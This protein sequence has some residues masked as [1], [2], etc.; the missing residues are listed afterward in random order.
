ML[1]LASLCVD[2]TARTSRMAYLRCHVHW[3]GHAAVNSLDYNPVDCMFE[4]NST[5]GLPV[6]N[7]L[8]FTRATARDWGQL[9]HLRVL[10]TAPLMASYRLIYVVHDTQSHTEHCF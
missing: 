8:Q 10:L 4:V 2:P 6:V 3:G 7:E 9:L 5:D 1:T